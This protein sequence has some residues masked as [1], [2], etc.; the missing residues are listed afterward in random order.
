MFKDTPFGPRCMPSFALWQKGK[1]RRIDDALRSLHN[2]LIY[3]HETIVC[4]T[5]DLPARI[6]AA[7][8]QHLMEE[9]LRQDI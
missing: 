1:C 2:I 8:A 6:A 9:S 4:E 7:F 5:A 3:M